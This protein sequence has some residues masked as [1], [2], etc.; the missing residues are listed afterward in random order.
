MIGTKDKKKFR[1]KIMEIYCVSTNKDSG[2]I[3]DCN[4][5]S[6]DQIYILNLLLSVI[7]MSVKINNLKKNLPSY[8]EI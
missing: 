5:Y 2:I 7:S 1:N 8:E 4:K 3:N 6:D